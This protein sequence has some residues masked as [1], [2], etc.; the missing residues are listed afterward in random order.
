MDIT[1]ESCVHTKI[2]QNSNMF[3]LTG[4]VR[5]RHTVETNT[6]KKKCGWFVDQLRLDQIGIIIDVADLRRNSDTLQLKPKRLIKLK[7]RE[8]IF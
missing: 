2:T 7:H 4:I 1:I 8:S 5:Q 3:Q 6:M